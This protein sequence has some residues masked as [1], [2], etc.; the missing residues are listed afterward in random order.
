LARADRP[1]QWQWPKVTLADPQQVQWR[2]PLGEALQRGVARLAEPPYSEPWLL[3]DVSFQVDRIFTNYSGDVSGRFLELA[4]LTSPAGRHSPATLDPVRAAISRFQ[5]P[6]GHFGAEVDLSKPLLK[7]SPPIPMLWGNGRLLV[8]LVTAGRLFHDPQLMASARRLGDFYVNTADQLCS[9]AREAEYHASGTGGDGYCCCYFPAIEGLAMLYRE[10]KDDRYLKMARRMA[11]FFR[12]F[13]VLP[14]DHS[15]GNLCAWRGI[16]ELYEITGD[17]GY[18]DRARAKWDAAVNGGYVWPTG[19]IGEHWYLNFGIDEG[20]SESDWLRFCLDL[21]RYTGEGRYLDVAERLLHNQYLANQCA[22]GGYGARHFEGQP[23]GP[24]TALPAL[25]EWNFCCNFHGPLGLFYTK[26]YLAAGSD[27]GVMVNFPEDFSAPVQAGGRTWQVTVHSRPQYMEG[28]GAE[29]ADYLNR[30]DRSKPKGSLGHVE[31]QIELTPH[32]ATGPVRTTLLVR[33]P[34][35]ADAY[36]VRGLPQFP[37]S[38]RQRQFGGY[39][40]IDAEFKEGRPVSVVFE[41]SLVAQ[42][43]RFETREPKKAEITRLPEVTLVVGP[44]VLYAA[45]AG[46]SGRPALLAIRS[47]EG[48]L[49][50]P[51]DGCVTALLPRIGATQHDI[52]YALESGRPVVLQPWPRK[53]S[54]RRQAFVY[55]LVVVPIDQLPVEALA[56]FAKRAKEAAAGHAGPIFG[57]DLE[58]R[59]EA[60][61][62]GADWKFTPEGLLVRGGEVGLLDGEGY[63]DYRFDFDLTLPKEGEGISG[64]VVRAG[65][66][67]DCLM[68]QLQSADSPFKASEFKTRP[69][70]LRPHTRRNGQWTVL[71]PVPLPKEVRRGE[72]HHV[73]VECRGEE[74]AVALD[75]QSIYRQKLPGWPAGA[76]GFRAA[77]PAEQGLFR[78]IHLE[79]L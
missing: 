22:N 7:N 28:P 11:E 73:T 79:R 70:T 64:W 56:S 62:P 20:C 60:W 43:R 23:S 16:L 24:T 49:C 50:L 18:L 15:H 10:T 27:R 34:A 1:Q 69:N 52:V 32:G 67:S 75:G 46:V 71:D 37:T 48:F 77:G 57:A 54:P 68:F 39:V 65:S 30:T 53:P 14:I 13:D 36:D 29:V 76:V 61:L 78:H 38:V 59:P 45:T 17:R 55:D 41:N 3:A 25:E 19:G 51:G 33:R 44:E 58:Q 42:G 5:K 63:A 2:G 66:E 8:G 4:S 74:I 6:D 40:T 21:W 12:K 47:K 26:S 9:P 35:W 72:S 31:L